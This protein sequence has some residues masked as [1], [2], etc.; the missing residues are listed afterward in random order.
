MLVVE[1]VILTEAVISGA[2]GAVAEFQ[3]RMFRV[4]P[5]ADGNTYGDTPAGLLS[6][7][8]DGQRF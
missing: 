7:A 2:A 6:S 3:V 5:A 8:A 4:G 1:N